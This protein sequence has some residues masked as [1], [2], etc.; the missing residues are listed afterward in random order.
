MQAE[1]A[2]GRGGGGAGGDGEGLIRTTMI[3]TIYLMRL[4]VVVII[5]VL[6]MN[7]ELC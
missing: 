2:R 1:Q 6:T 5:M 4:V 3:G 7:A